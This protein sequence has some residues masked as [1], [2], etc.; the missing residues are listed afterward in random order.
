[1]R[2]YSALSLSLSL[3]L[4]LF[5]TPTPAIQCSENTFHQSPEIYTV[6]VLEN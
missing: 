2:I 5:S 1:M 3:S 4:S 6:C